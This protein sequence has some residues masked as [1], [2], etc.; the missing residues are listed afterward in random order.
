MSRKGVLYVAL[1]FLVLGTSF[2]AAQA[3]VAFTRADAIE[4]V[5]TYVD[6]LV[7]YKDALGHPMFKFSGKDGCVN[8]TEIQNAKDRYLKDLVRSAVDL[9]ETNEKIMWD[10]DYDTTAR[11][12]EDTTRL[13]SGCISREDMQMSVDHCISGGDKLERLKKHLCDRAKAMAPQP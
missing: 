13:S 2:T 4:C 11:S 3:A 5:L 12:R 7:K 6:G 9:V 8:I 1:F 10:C